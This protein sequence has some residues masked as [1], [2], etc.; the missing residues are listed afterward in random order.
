MENKRII[1]L[2]PITTKNYFGGVANFD[3]ELN[4]AFLRA[5]YESVIVTV[6]KD[7]IHQKE[8]NVKQCG[9][10]FD[11]YKF[12]KAYSPRMVIAALQY[13][14]FF[15][16]LP[17]NLKKIYV[18]HGFFDRVYYSHLKAI[19]APLYQKLVTL[20]ADRVV[21]NSYFTR[22]INND[23]FNIQADSVIHLGVA[24]E[25]LEKVSQET[26]FNK[27]KHSIL[28]AGRL[29]KSKRP[30]MLLKALN[31]LKEKKLD[32][33][34]Y[35]AGNGEEK[36]NLLKYAH[37]NG[38]NMKYLGSLS[39]DDLYDYYKRSEVFVSLND[40]EPMGI[41][42]FEAVLLHCKIISPFTGGQ[43]ESLYD[44]PTNTR[45]FVDADSPESIANGIEKMFLS[46]SDNLGPGNLD[47]SYEH[48]VKKF[49]EL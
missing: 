39:H 37:E 34:L 20:K 36:E 35:L 22:M 16:I 19:L 32:Y 21:S 46:S 18:L 48:V 44:L 11:V 28:F 42:F 10:F 43:V 5:G 47:L 15:Y 24:P 41:V 17:K 9:S 6:Q 30:L 8:S 45:C 40:S 1:I 4:E 29:I 33:I 2:G 26:H 13:G 3:E 14:A 31:V 12:I 23:F 38:I 49:L 25:Y 7:L 27:E